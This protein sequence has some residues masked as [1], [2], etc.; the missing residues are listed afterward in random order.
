MSTSINVSS[1]YFAKKGEFVSRSI[2]GEEVVVPVRGQ[3]GDLE[4]IY[5]LNEVGAFIWRLI[6]GRTSL[7]Q[8]IDAVCAEFEVAAEEAEKDTV[9]FVA[10]LEEA[11]MI[12][13]CGPG[14]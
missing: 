11:G 8:I 3:V 13:P 9:E 7:S 4:S 2:A 10:A 5:N 6:D 14:D 12:E 1:A